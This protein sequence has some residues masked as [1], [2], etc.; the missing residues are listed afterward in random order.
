MKTAGKCVLVIIVLLIIA[1]VG[2]VAFLYSGIYNVSASYPD[3]KLADW[4][5]STTSDNSVRRHAR[6]VKAQPLDDPALLKRGAA[7]FAGMCVGCHG[8]PGTAQD[9][10]AE[11]LMPSPPEYTE[12]TEDWTSSEVFWIVKNGIRMTAMPCFGKT[13]DDDAIWA[14][15]AFTEQLKTLSPDDYKKAVGAA[16]P[17]DEDEKP[18]QPAK[19]AAGAPKKGA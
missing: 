5:F 12:L 15:V 19:P 16:G 1:G 18:G 10:V 3:S 14:I 8:A 9:E 4:V 6:S 2:A 17:M 13:H 7:H 11:G